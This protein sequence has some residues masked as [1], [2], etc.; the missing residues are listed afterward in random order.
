MAKKIV[1]KYMNFLRS[2]TM[3][4][5]GND[6]DIVDEVQTGCSVRAKLAMEIHMVDFEIPPPVNGPSWTEM[7][8]ASD[9]ISA[10]FAV[11]AH[12]A[13]NELIAYQESNAVGVSVEAGMQSHRIDFDPPLLYAFTSIFFGARSNATTSANIF[14]GRI[15]FTWKTLTDAEYIEALESWR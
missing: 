2:G 11:Q 14:S 12:Y 9:D 6:L 15:G 1:D 13:I 7:W 4:Q 3:L 10:L 8:L 5:P